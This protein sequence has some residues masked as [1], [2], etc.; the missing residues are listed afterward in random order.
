MPVLLEKEYKCYLNHLDEFVR[1][2]CHKF[3]L[4]KDDQIIDFFPTYEDALKSGLKQ[5]GNVAFFIKEVQKKEERLFFHQR[6]Q[7]S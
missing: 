3:V 4:I 1:H 5:F 7:P 2:H 6:I